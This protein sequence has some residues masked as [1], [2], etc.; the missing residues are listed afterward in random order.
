LESFTSQKFR[1]FATTL[2]RCSQVKVGLHRAGT[3]NAS[4]GLNGVA[5]QV[6]MV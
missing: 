2:S 5:E 6:V 3:G 1:C 4:G